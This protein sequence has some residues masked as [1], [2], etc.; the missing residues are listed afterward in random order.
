MNRK[1]LLIPFISLAVFLTVL[2]AHGQTNIIPYGTPLIFNYSSGDYKASPENYG[3]VQNSQ[4]VLYIGNTGY[5]L[6]YDGVNWRKIKIDGELPVLSLAID[7]LGT[8]YLSTG[9]EFG[10][11]QPDASG[12][13]KYVSLSA[14]LKLNE[15]HQN[16]IGNVLLTSKKLCF[17]TPA[18]LVVYP[19][20]ITYSKKRKVIDI[21]KP[22]IIES[23]TVFTNSY[24]AEDII[25]V[26][27]KEQGLFQLSENKLV[28]LK[29]KSFLKWKTI[30]ILPYSADRVVIC[31]EKGIYFYKFKYGFMKFDS[32]TDL[33]L[34]EISILSATILPDMF[35]F[36][37]LNKGTMVID[38]KLTGKKRKIIEKYSKL[39]GLPT[40]QINCI[41]N[42][43]YYDANLLWMT[44][45]YGISKT[46]INS[47]VR[48]INEAADV[49]DIINDI[50]RNDKTLYVKTLGEVYYLKDTL[51]TYRFLKV[52][53]V[54]STSDWLSLP[55]E[56]ST[57]SKDKKKKFFKLFSKKTKP[58][59]KIEPR[60]ILA[61]KN[62]LQLI[63]GVDAEFIKPNLK[64]LYNPKAKRQNYALVNAGKGFPKGINKLYRSKKN[65]YRIFAGLTNG[66]AVISYQNGKWIDEGT[67]EEITENI[68]GIVEDTLGNLWLSDNSGGAVSII[69]PDTNLV[70]KTPAEYGSKKDSLSYRFFPKKLFIQRFDES[71]GLPAMI[72]NG[73]F[74]V[75][76]KAL[77]STKKGLFTYLLKSDG[78][79]EFKPEKKFGSEFADGY[80]QVLSLVQDAKGNCWMRIKSDFYSG[81]TYFI[82]NSNGTYRRH[83]ESLKLFPEMI[84]ETI[85]PDKN[86]I[87]WVSGSQGLYV[88]NTNVQTNSEKKF[89]TL[90]RRVTIGKDSVIFGG[91]NYRYDDSLGIWV[92]SNS[93]DIS[94]V[95]KIFYKLNSVTFDYAAP[96]YDNESVTMFQYYMEGLDT[97]WSDWTLSS[98]KE[99]SSLPAGKYVFRVKAKN[100]YDNESSIAEFK[101]RIIPPWYKS[102]WAYILYFIAL[103]GIVILIIKF[104]SRRLV[105]EKQYLERIVEERTQEVVRQK[106]EIELKNENITNSI[107]YAKRIQQAMLPPPG[108]F[109][110][111]SVKDYLI[112][113]KP[114]DIV[115]GDFYFFT[116]KVE[117][118]YSSKGKS[119][120]SAEVIAAVDCT[121]H[122]IPGAFM[123]MIGYS[124]LNDIVERNPP[125]AALILG[126]LHTAIRTSLQQDTTDNVDGMD[127]A[128]VVI[129]DNGKTLEYAGAM[130]SLTYIQNGELFVIKGNR[131]GIGGKHHTE[132]RVFTKHSISIDKPTTVYLSSDGY[133]D[134]F[135]GEEG[136]KLM[137]ANFRK[138]LVEIH[139][140]P[141]FEQKE[142]LKQ[143]LNEWM[144]KEHEQLDDILVIGFKV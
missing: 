105:K 39:A 57:L 106:H 45:A 100:I 78:T 86:G 71:K 117:E 132:T 120:E 38:R 16:G 23:K 81:I 116:K 110:N 18:S 97:I 109:G 99:Y 4:G 63:D 58:P 141:M 68:T 82:R 95:P 104:N 137:A 127:I 76:G 90:I 133:Q 83:D 33:Y 31:T 135:G 35:V 40:E 74:R 107:N 131:F 52:S 126:K 72:E 111:L 2:N 113:F 29:N 54:S 108:N 119:R 8:V 73:L 128:L 122:G 7:S 66:I 77:L 36:A 121:G 94:V 49:K 101:F 92:L 103:A 60:V 28:A 50:I 47:S 134:Q 89:N 26:D 19:Q 143:K 67:I 22:D 30:A 27:Q 25:F 17:Q 15:T 88:F 61:S 37:T 114:R 32:E 21:P 75:D 53:K 41:Y 6:E 44:S 70:Y 115:S 84:V 46:Q 10:F 136:Y 3:L 64:V 5:V 43:K 85:Y 124:L 98:R 48:K 14:D 69:V 20:Y 1:S 56:V 12:I 130:N 125:D 62:G 79:I 140:K 93:Q 34:D 55:I 9:T 24:A 65:N 96:F 51:D 13:L 80:Y 139:Q 123:S 59:V 91:S 11:L 144:G 87:V 42:N 129:K 138:I 112:F 102:W 142:I 118:N